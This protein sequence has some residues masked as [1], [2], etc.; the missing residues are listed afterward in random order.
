MAQ[1]G[2]QGLQVDLT[3]LIQAFTQQG[4][5]GFLLVFINNQPL[6]PVN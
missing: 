4:G 3:G 1:V 5:K 6:L 2:K